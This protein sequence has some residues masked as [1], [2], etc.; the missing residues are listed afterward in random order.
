M[1]DSRSAGSE[2]TAPTSAATTAASSREAGAPLAPEWATT[3]AP[4][5]ANES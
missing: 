2:M 5:P 4:I 3:T 1:P